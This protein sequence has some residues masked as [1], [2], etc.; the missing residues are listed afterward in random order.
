[1]KLLFD[2]DSEHGHVVE[3]GPDGPIYRDD[4]SLVDDANPRPCFGCKL[5]VKVG[6]PDPCTGTLPGTYQAC[7]GHGL[8][9]SPRTG[10]PNGYV[11]LNDG[12][13]LNFSG[14]VGAQAIRTAVDAALRNEDLPD[15][16][17]FDAERMWWEGLTDA[18]VAYVRANIVRDLI[19]MVRD[20]RGGKSL[21]PPS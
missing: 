14:C 3:N 8:D 16:F 2:V 9:K 13:V 12:R 10:R 1:M 11:A 5:H 19:V 7:C 6:E 21:P 20:A 4:K 17:V 15:G 18:Q